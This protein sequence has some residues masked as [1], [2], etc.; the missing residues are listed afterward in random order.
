MGRT[1]I[2]QPPVVYSN[3]G[4]PCYKRFAINEA[5]GNNGTAG[6]FIAIMID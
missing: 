2:L 5:P 4:F 6:S 3:P 1:F